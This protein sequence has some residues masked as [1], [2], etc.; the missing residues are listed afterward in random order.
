M[1]YA[2]APQDIVS[3]L[4]RAENDIK[5]L[6]RR[7]GLNSA[8][9]DHGVIQLRG[10]SRI[11]AIDA[12]DDLVFRLG[13]LGFV[14]ADGRN[15]QGIEMRYEHDSPAIA[16]WN[17]GA[18]SVA[19]KQFVAI[20]DVLGN[21]IMSSDANSEFG[22]ARPWL[23][24]AFQRARTT[25]WAST[26]SAAYE[27]VTEAWTHQHHPWFEAR[28]SI[29]GNPGTTGDARVMVAGTQVGDLVTYDGVTATTVF[30]SA[31]V[32]QVFGTLTQVKVEA[33]RIAGA[34]TIFAKIDAWWRQ[35]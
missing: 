14:Y 19:N 13:S 17:P 5:D 33:R 10:D 1:A 15:Q 35:S 24:I 21:I 3:R 2:D 11:E 4:R 30:R 27:N 32:F 16:V 34:G 29:T 9:I 22:M 20:Y 6:R 12:E 25:D 8:T 26:V 7:V 31:R 18:V 23:P 28:V